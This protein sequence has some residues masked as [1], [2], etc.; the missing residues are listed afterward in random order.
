[1]SM[2]AAMCGAVSRQMLPRRPVRAACLATLLPPW[3]LGLVCA[4][5]IC[6][7]PPTVQAQRV[8]PQLVHLAADDETLTKLAVLYYGDALFAAVLANANAL[9]QGV[10]TRL[11]AGQRLLI[12]H[13]SEMRLD[14][15]SSFPRVAQGLL[16]E[17]YRQFVL[18]ELNESVQSPRLSPGTVLNVPPVLQHTLRMGETLEAVASR[19]GLAAEAGAQLLRRYNASVREKPRQ[20]TVIDVPLLEI[21]LT[22]AARRKLDALGHWA[23]RRPTRSDAQSGERLIELESL[24][25]ASRFS[26]ALVLAARLIGELEPQGAPVSSY[27]LLLGQ[28]LVALGNEPAARLAF[29]AALA[30]TPSARLD[31]TLTSPKIIEVFAAAQAERARLR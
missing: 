31:P 17:S 25:R 16:G 18:R 5:A 12:P 26:D 1:M 4:L 29:D 24:L 22:A 2:L 14:S 27:H 9:T 8:G 21:R 3:A 28:A 30:E 20:G 13:V 11:A 23:C 15:A 6:V 10:D 19:Y 7:H